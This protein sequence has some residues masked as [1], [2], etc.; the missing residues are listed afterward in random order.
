MQLLAM[1]FCNL[2]FWVRIP[3][4]SLCFLLEKKQFG[5]C[6]K[7][8][9]V[10][11][12][13]WSVVTVENQTWGNCTWMFGPSLWLWAHTNLKC[14]ICWTTKSLTVLISC[15]S[16]NFL[17]TKFS[18]C[19]IESILITIPFVFITFKVRNALSNKLEVGTAFP[20]IPV[21]CNHSVEDYLLV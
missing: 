10:S 8:V 1:H 9:T 2:Q 7:L 20:C 11:Q 3:W 13:V 6:T 18:L 21:H 12:T 16:T 5:K 15:I 17:H 19:T 14:I 4:L